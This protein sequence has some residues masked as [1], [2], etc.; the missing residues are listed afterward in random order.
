M[1]SAS[2]LVRV[3]YWSPVLVC[4]VL[5]A[6]VSFLGLRPALCERRRLAESQTMLEAR[7]ARDLALRD[8]ATLS[9]RVRAD[10]IFLERQRRSRW[11]GPAATDRPA[12][13]AGE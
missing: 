10:P 2:F 6:Q 8:Q 12:P 13:P 4:M 9:L 7:H 3:L 11:I 1:R 5:F